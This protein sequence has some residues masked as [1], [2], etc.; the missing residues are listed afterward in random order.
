MEMWI[1][2]CLWLVI[3]DK[4]L[5]DE[6]VPYDLMPWNSRTLPNFPYT[7]QQDED[8]TLL[9][10]TIYLSKFKS[11]DISFFVSKPRNGKLI[12]DANAFINHTLC[13]FTIYV[14]YHIICIT[15]KGYPFNCIIKIICYV[16]ISCEFLYI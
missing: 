2:I 16:I 1:G 14:T 13:K 15:I 6:E 11:Q 12:N 5:I 3:T 4:Y 7:S 9:H 10:T 8:N